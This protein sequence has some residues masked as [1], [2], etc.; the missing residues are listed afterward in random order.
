METMNKT[1]SMNKIFLMILFT[2]NYFAC[3]NAVTE[4]NNRSNTI[5]DSTSNKVNSTAT[6]GLGSDPTRID[7]SKKNP[8]SE[9]AI[10]SSVHNSRTGATPGL[11][12]DPTRNDPSKSP[13]SPK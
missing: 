11:G 1:F 12:S 2:L 8:I 3:K 7:A 10:D 9:Q 6:P 5:A 13:S 4:N